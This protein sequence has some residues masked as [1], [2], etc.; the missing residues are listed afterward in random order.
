MSATPFTRVMACMCLA[1]KQ[2]VRDSST[3]HSIHPLHHGDEGVHTIP[4]VMGTHT[5][6][7][8]GSFQ[9]RDIYI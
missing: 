5:V 3:M 4:V 1:L 8:Q 2:Y 7:T 6:E 9:N